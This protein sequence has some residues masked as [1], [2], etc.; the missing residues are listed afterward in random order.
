VSDLPISKKNQAVVLRTP[1]QR[2]RA[3]WAWFLKSRW[4]DIVL[5]FAG[6]V[7][8]LFSLWVGVYA[9]VNPDEAKSYFQKY[10]TISAHDF[11]VLRS[12]WIW[13]LMIIGWC[14]AGLSWR[15]AR[16]RREIAAGLQAQLTALTKATEQ[17]PNR[18]WDT[19]RNIVYGHIEYTP[20]L[21]YEQ[22]KKDPGGFGVYYLNKLLGSPK[23]VAAKAEAKRRSSWDSVFDEMA[24]GVCDVIATPLFATFDRSS[25]VRFSSPLFYSNVGLYMNTDAMAPSFLEG[26]SVQNLTE[27]LKEN[28]YTSTNLQFLSIKGEISEKL[29]MKYAGW[30]VDERIGQFLIASLLSEIASCKLPSRALFCE[31]Y[32][33]DQ[34]IEELRRERTE[35]GGPPFPDV[36][37]VLPAQSILFPVCFAV[38][39]ADYELANLLNIRLLQFTQKKSALDELAEWLAKDRGLVDTVEKK[40][41]SDFIKDVK[42]HFVAAWP[43]EVEMDGTDA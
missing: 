42:K 38:P 39:Y 35:A 2:L 16:K 17:I 28:G 10:G 41:R 12:V 18:R 25:K 8:A 7:I 22:D 33:A 23:L 26:L 31:S 29:A 30:L 6:T 32:I 15:N 14:L 5:W 19:I 24:P 3:S 34:M 1:M 13:G 20:F 21:R 40:G 43:L 4:F 9:S 36:A 11:D 27:R 37:N